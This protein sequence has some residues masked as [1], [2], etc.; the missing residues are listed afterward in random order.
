MARADRA[1]LSGILLDDRFQLG[2]TLGIGGTSVVFEA[3]DLST[4]QAVVV[5]VLRDMFAFNVELIRRMRREAEVAQRV[6]HPGIV[7][8]YSEG[9]LDD[10]SPY[11]VLERLDGECCARLLRRIGPMEPR[12]VAA[13]ALRAA[14][15]LHA[16][17]SRGYVHRDVKPEHIV[18]AATPDGFLDVRLLDFGVCASDTADEDERKA[19]RGRVYGTPAYCSPEQA[20]GKPD[21]DGRADVFSLGTTMFEMMSGR[22]PFVGDNV[23]NLLRRIIRED[24]PRIGLLLPELDLRFDTVVTRAMARG[25]QDRFPSARA[26]ARAMLPLVGDRRQTEH[27][28]AS[29]IRHRSPRQDLVPTVRE[30]LAHLAVA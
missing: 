30:D 15:I 21:V 11:L 3:D 17:H 18:L 7:P 23:A 27:E 19:E 4:G 2:R 1:E 14:A 16:S 26:M 12:H 9:M 10:G 24:A 25:P 5:K 22:V 13:I 6:M 29:M 28:I 8:V 20:R